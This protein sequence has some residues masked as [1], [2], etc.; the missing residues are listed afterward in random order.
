MHSGAHVSRCACPNLRVVPSFDAPLTRNRAGEGVAPA[1]LNV[2]SYAQR[3]GA[4]LIITEG[5]QPSAVGQGY[6]NTPGM[7]SDAQIQGW[8]NVADAV[9]ERGGKIVVQLMR[10]G[11]ISHSDNKNGLEAIASS[12]LAAPG[13]MVTAEGSKPHPTPP[14]CVECFGDPRS[15]RGLRV[16]VTQREAGL[17]GVEI[18]PR[19]ATSCTSSFHRPATSAPTGT[20]AR[21]SHWAA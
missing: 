9:H 12:A 17:D 13:E 21:P 7:H 1:D 18:A 11:R 4:G 3:A 2:E 14:P 6:L 16:G 5:T 19:T 15:D 8:R 20:A 10:E